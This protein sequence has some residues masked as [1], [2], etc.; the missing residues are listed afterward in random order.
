WGIAIS[1]ITIIVLVQRK[2]QLGVA[3][4]IGSLIAG[5]FSGQTLFS[6]LEIAG[7][8]VVERTAVTLILTLGLISL[9]GFIMQELSLLTKMVNSLQITLRSTKLTIMFVPSIIGTLLVH[10]GAIMSAPLV[11]KLGDE[12][13]LPPARQ[14][15]INL[16]FRHGWY[17][18]YPIMPAFVLVTGITGL[19]L[20]RLLV[21]QIPLT[22][23]M[24][25]SG[26][27][28]YLRKVPDKGHL[29]PPAKKQDYLNLLIF[30]SPIW[31][32]LFLTVGVNISFP[33]A[34]LAGISLALIIA[35]PA[36]KNILPLFW[37]G[38]NFPII[39]SGAAIMIFK[40]VTS[41]IDALPP[42]IDSILATG[43]PA[44]LLF[45]L[46]PL[47]TG[48]V[49]ASNTS[50]LGLTLPLLLPSM[51]N[52]NLLFFG[53]MA[54]YT[55]SFLGYFVSPIHLCQVLTL[56]QLKAKVM[57]LYREYLVPIV[58]VISTITILGLFINY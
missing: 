16:V 46:L 8:A 15:A 55:G 39:I 19:S 30:T 4:L 24:I 52:A 42:L 36:T 1:F 51:L 33:I 38:I 57:P 35:K 28:V 14:A 41:R 25:L 37:R 27:L 53:T 6:L 7:K 44:K 45:F 29:G 23:A 31:V 9:L 2:V 21:A 54:A 40:A 11:G 50:A 17:F 10:G 22:I 48:I 20:S 43:M 32:S 58:S 13:D 18:I 26:Y 3:L 5:L 34:L 49:S 56:A 47:M 12:L